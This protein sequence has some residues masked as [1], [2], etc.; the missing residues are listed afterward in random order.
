MARSP[1]LQSTQSLEAILLYLFRRYTDHQGRLPNK[2]LPLSSRKQPDTGLG[3]R[4]H[5]PHRFSF[6]R[7]RYDSARPAR[8]EAQIL[9][10]FI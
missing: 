8:S 5:D 4:L 9:Y 7:P 10:D 6:T 1:T 3:W 2:D